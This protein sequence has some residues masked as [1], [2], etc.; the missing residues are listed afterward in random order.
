M[1]R[2]TAI[3]FNPYFLPVLPTILLAII[4][5]FNFER[6][7]LEVK[8]HYQENDGYYN[9]YAD[10][11]NDGYSEHIRIVDREDGLVSLMIYDHQ[12]NLFFQWNFTGGT[13]LFR[14]SN[15]ELMIL[16]YN[17]NGIKSVSFLTH[18]NDSIL[19]HL[20]ED[21][22][23][24]E[25]GVENRFITAVGPGLE[26]SFLRVITGEGEDLNG[27]GDKEFVFALVAGFPR[28]PRNVF[29]YSVKENRVI[30]SPESFY[31]FR[32]IYQADVTG[33]GKME[34][35][36]NGVSTAN[37][38]PYE[39]PYHD[40]SNWLMVLDQNL[41]FL[42]EPVELP[43]V[44][45]LIHPKLLRV[46]N[47][48]LIAVFELTPYNDEPSIAHFFDT[49]GVS[50]WTVQLSIS[51][52]SMHYFEDG[53]DMIFAFYDRPEGIYVYK[54]SIENK[55]FHPSI[56]LQTPNIFDI[57][58]DGR[59]EI[60]IPNPSSARVYLF[61]PDM[62]RPAGADINVNLNSRRRQ[63]VSCIE[64]PGEP[65]LI[66]YQV[67]NDCYVLSYGLNPAFYKS[68]FYL[69]MIYAGLLGFSLLTRRIQRRQIDKKNRVEKKITELQLS[70][71]K[72]Q[73]NPHFSMNAINS[74]IQ[75][76]R[77]KETD[78]AADYLARFSRLHREVLF[79]A[80]SVRR[81]LGDEVTFCEDY[82]E[83]ER[84]S[85]ENSFDAKIH[86]APE[87]DLNIMVPKMLI[88]IYAENAI[89]HGLAPKG[90][91]GLLDIRI[92]K[93]NGELLIT[94]KDNGVGRNAA[95][96]HGKQSTGMGMG[97]MEEYFK[98][99]HDY[100]RDRI[101]F[102]IE[103]LFDDKGKAAGTRVR[104]RIIFVGK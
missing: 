45:N 11:T 67:D 50:Q 27:N 74:A 79:S 95:N 16:D 78:R 17:N 29:A 104:I 103:D 37:V 59:R 15:P 51:P 64:R 10:L 6:Y 53:D 68:F 19:L 66:S 20:V 9:Y 24:P 4:L 100:Y 22:T 23:T 94:I 2:F 13:R 83:L 61:R 52:R 90:S 85:F 63:L 14:Y 3:V 88:Q 89:K 72:N 76:I 75:S 87:V 44:S 77:E 33:N 98:L 96:A 36:L 58:N 56:A 71:V 47:K 73:L 7:A 86:V 26:S 69:L 97:I 1:K 28:Y 34:I 91:G 57:N 25:K 60:F 65:A 49:G 21:I 70:L 35:L 42:F 18:H 39:H 38:A 55:R 93:N 46:E 8:D 92:I 31:K 101:I 30:R 54:N 12:G 62:T 82:I 102:D 84:L 32:S 5:P 43:G 41:E 48:D 81:T 99:Y 40:H 80:K